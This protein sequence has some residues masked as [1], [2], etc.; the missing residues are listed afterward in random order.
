M[1][2]IQKN[3]FAALGLSLAFLPLNLKA[4]NNTF[5]LD[6]AKNLPE[7]SSFAEKYGNWN[8]LN[9]AIKDKPF[10]AFGAPI[11]IDNFDIVNESNIEEAARHFI[12]LNSKE[13]N[14]ETRNLVLASAVKVNQLWYVRFYQTYQNL[15][16]VTST[17]EL[18][19]K[20]DANVIGFGVKTFDNINISIKPEIDANVARSVVFKDLAIDK[21]KSNSVLAEKEL[22]ITPVK[23]NGKYEYKLAYSFSV[24]K[25]LDSYIIFVDAKNSQ[26]I[27]KRKTSTNIETNV[28]CIGSTSG[29]YLQDPVSNKAFANQIFTVN[30]V[31]DTADANGNATININ[32]STQIKAVLESPFISVSRDTTTKNA[33]FSGTAT[34]GS[35]FTIEWNDNNSHKFERNLFHYATEAYKMYKEID[36]TSAVMDTKIKIT[37]YFDSNGMNA[38]SGGKSI[39]FIGLGLKNNKMAEMPDIY[40]HEYGHSINKLLYD[41]LSKSNYGMLNLACNE[42]LADINSVIY[43]GVSKVGAGYNAAYPSTPI[44]NVENSKV[45]PTDIESDD[46][47]TGLILSGA[48]WDLKKTTSMDYIKKVSHFARYGMPDD[49][50]YGIAFSEWLIETLTADDNLYG[51]AD[52]SNGTPNA[53][54]IIEA[55][56]KHNIGMNLYLSRT[57]SYSQEIDNIELNQDYAIS[58]KIQEMNS[59]GFYLDSMLVVY[60]NDNFKTTNTIIC[61]TDKQGNFTN[62]IPAFNKPSVVK[63]YFKAFFR[64]MTEPL[65]FYSNTSNEPYKYMVDYMRKEF[66]Q[67]ETDKG[68]GV[69]VATDKATQAVW[70]R[71]APVQG[72]SYMSAYMPSADFTDN[73]TICYVTGKN[74]SSQNATNYTNGTT[75]LVS[76]NY[77]ITNLP[78]PVLKFQLWLNGVSWVEGLTFN[79]KIIVYASTNDGVNWKSCGIYKEQKAQWQTMFIPISDY[80]TNSATNT[81]K[82]KFLFDPN[83]REGY[84]TFA[85]AYIDEV[86]VWTPK[87]AIYSVEDDLAMNASVYPNPSNSNF[88]FKVNMK[89]AGIG[90]LII[91]NLLGVK[92]Y[93]SALLN[94]DS[95]LNNINFN[96]A[97]LSSG[98]YFYQVINGDEIYSGSIIKN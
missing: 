23:A 17:L 14:I 18:R 59:F 83:Y 77:D 98:T 92:L 53:L 45:Y 1:Q 49:Y 8:L 78:N 58:G 42:A 61:P 57:F 90:K 24:Q 82:F 65:T 32:N 16:V 36:S 94:F 73:G 81:I 12:S 67:F 30:G 5:Y 31:K 39:N 54:K 62:A 60:S 66:D 22:F 26:I 19:I 7:W 96:G 80:I 72:G 20:D 56:N 43:T 87:T 10:R 51:D 95:G 88:N 64:N 52:L 55:F 63:Y 69:G 13:F 35:P 28:E 21:E 33:S 75:S 74:I 29:V 38:S 84:Y 41:N 4:Q 27:E 46:H 2:I 9:D 89:N 48:F 71:S 93:E 76:P 50:D 15:R 40:F 68:W 91:S 70:E 37:L 47:N 85:K 86:Q 11:K 25:D 3:I 34:P 79:P 97:D 6:N 44:R